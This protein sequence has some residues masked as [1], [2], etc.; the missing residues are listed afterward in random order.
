[1]TVSDGKAGSFITH[2]VGRVHSR[3]IFDRR[4]IVLARQLAALL[5]P[6]SRL[7]DVGCGDGSLGA[8]LRGLVPGLHVEG[9]EVHARPG[10]AVP[11]QLFDG[12]HLPF[13][14]NSFDVCLFVD[15]LHHSQTPLVILQD[16]CRVSRKFVLIKDHFSESRFDYWTLRLMDWV[17]NA[18]HG[19]S[20]PYNYFSRAQW[21]DAFRR[22]SLVPRSTQTHLPLYLPPLSWLFGSGLHFI[23]LLEKKDG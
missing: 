2:L 9:V 19:V 16:A 6:G 10:C 11:F 13:P 3:L 15:V 20:L 12:Q 4:K 22:S 8:L 21:D 18:P 7:L 5:P 17:G 23:S 14:D 1:M